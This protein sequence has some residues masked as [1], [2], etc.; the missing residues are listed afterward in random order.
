MCPC[1]IKDFECRNHNLKVEYIA[2]NYYDM[3]D[4][5]IIGENDCFISLDSKVMSIFKDYTH[6]IRLPLD[7]N[8]T[9]ENFEQKLKTYL[10]F[11]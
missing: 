2:L 5:Y 10:N 8:L 6:L 7:P 11:L 3:E 4:Y 1:N 9:P